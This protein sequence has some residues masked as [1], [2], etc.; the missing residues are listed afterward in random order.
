MN[1]SFGK[2]VWVLLYAFALAG[3]T[4][5]ATCGSYGPDPEDEEE[6]PEYSTED[7]MM[8]DAIRDSER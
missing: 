7:E 6:S 2:V 3:T 5:F 8:E 1:P 4:G